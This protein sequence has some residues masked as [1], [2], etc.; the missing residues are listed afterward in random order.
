MSANKIYRT[1]KDKWALVHKNGEIVGSYSLMAEDSA[2]TMAD[3]HV[4]RLLAKVKQK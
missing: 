4:A 1:V 2:L 3:H